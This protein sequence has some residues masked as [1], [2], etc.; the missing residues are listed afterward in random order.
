MDFSVQLYTTARTRITFDNCD[1]E[2]GTIARVAAA[3]VAAD[4]ETCVVAG[5][6]SGSE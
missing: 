1:A 3:A 2:H 4:G 5:R 6:V